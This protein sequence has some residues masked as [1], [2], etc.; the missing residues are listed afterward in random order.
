MKKLLFILM[1]CLSIIS[2]NTNVTTDSGNTY[3]PEFVDYAKQFNLL[4]NIDTINLVPINAQAFQILDEKTCLATELSNKEYNW[5]HGNILYIFTNELLYDD[6]IIND[7]LVLLGT[8]HYTSRDS[9]PR[10]VKAYATQDF[11]KEYKDVFIDI[12]NINN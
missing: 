8:Y 11:Y 7:K 12:K 9:L 1:M 6:I 4:E 5:Y 2:C 10:T 3:D